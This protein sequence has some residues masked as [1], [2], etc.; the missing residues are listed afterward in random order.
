MMNE[1]AWF[2]HN[3]GHLLVGAEAKGDLPLAGAGETGNS[4]IGRVKPASPP[5]HDRSRRSGEIWVKPAQ[6]TS[7]RKRVRRYAP[8]RNPALFRIFVDVS[9]DP[10]SV[11]DFANRFGLLTD[12]EKGESLTTWKR[13]IAEFRIAV[14]CWERGAFPSDGQKGMAVIRRPCEPGFAMI[15]GPGI[16]SSLS[17]CEL[18]DVMAS[19]I[20]EKISNV[21][22]VFISHTW[23]DP[24]ADSLK[25][26][27]MPNNLLEAMWLQFGQAVESNKSFRQCRQCD[28]WF[29]LS[30]KVARSDK[31]FC[32]DA[33]KAKAYRRRL[34]DQVQV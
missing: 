2:V 31:I 9:G 18:V 30:P 6:S 20:S 10:D 14:E 8:L 1:F 32:T 13:A 15:I 27:L 5:E 28:D 16:S 29:E 34:A 17:D 12:A 4:E 19:L 24:L 7:S 23:D 33:C 22:P 25:L 3:A 11:V 26:L 21:R